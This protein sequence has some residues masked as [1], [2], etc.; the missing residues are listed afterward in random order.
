MKK[1]IILTAL[2]LAGWVQSQVA[3][4]KTTLTNSS[5]ALEFGSDVRG[6][7]LPLVTDATT[8]TGTNGSMVFDAATGSFRFYAN[9]VWS[10]ATSGGQT[11]GAPTGSDTG[12]GVIVGANSS[13]ATGALIIESSNRALV[14][15]QAI[16]VGQRSITGVKGLA[17]WDPALKAVAVYDGVKWNYY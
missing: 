8:M 16:L 9:N 14:L 17:I 15:P 1:I 13:S 2:T 5:V 4:G 12:S 10:A 6:I 7:R 3:I 11:G